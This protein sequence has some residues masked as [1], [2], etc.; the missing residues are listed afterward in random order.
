MKNRLIIDNDGSNYFLYS[1]NVQN[2]AD[3]IINEVND[4]PEC[5]TTV[6]L[7]PGAGTFWYPT[8]IG[9]V[10]VKAFELK[11]L[12]DRKID[13][14]RLYLETL[15]KSGKEVFITIRMNDVHTPQLVNDGNVPVIR[16]KYPNITVEEN[17]CPDEWMDYCLDYSLSE[18]RTYMFGIIKELYELYGEIIDGIILDWMRFPRF[19]SG[20]PENRWEKHVFLND[21]I[22]QVRKL[23]KGIELGARIP[24]I[25]SGAKFIGLNLEY[26]FENEL[27]DFIIGC[28]FLT[29]DFYINTVD[30]KK[31]MKKQIPVYGGCD[32]GHTPQR[33]CPE[34]LRGI[35]VGMYESGCDGLYLFNFPCWREYL[36]CIPWHWL[37]SIKSYE[38]AQNGPLLVSVPHKLYRKEGIDRAGILPLELS[39]EQSIDLEVILPSI[40]PEAKK[41]MCLIHSCDDVELD[42]NGQK[43][44]LMPERNEALFVEYTD[45][46]QWKKFRPGMGET[47]IF[48]I[49]K[50]SSGTNLLTIKNRSKNNIHIERINFGIW[51]V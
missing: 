45:Q 2:Y 7:C 3:E 43:T 21:F 4:I 22:S 32:I 16:E 29:S 37:S 26:C 41:T 12:L 25:L 10:N 28:P 24:A 40:T 51:P 30:F 46:R 36:G 49:P 18:V 34:S 14:F 38:E 5:V 13:P 27:F 48:R 42:I 33:H 31:L 9:K 1:L 47:R 11:K 6:A 23:T 17:P 19:L 15:K 20:L 44:S 8:Q 50:A 35:A 39:P